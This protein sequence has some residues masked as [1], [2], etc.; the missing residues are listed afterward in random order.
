MTALATEFPATRPLVVARGG[1][2]RW[3]RHPFLYVGRTLDKRRAF[4]A[5]LTQRGYRVAPVTIENADY[6]YA[7]VYSDAKTRGDRAL[8]RQ[9]ADDYL[10]FTERKFVFF[11]DISRRLFGRNIDHVLLLHDNE[12]NAA[13]IDRL[14]ALIQ[15]RGYDFAP[16]ETVLRDP[17]Y[18][19]PDT[20]AG[21]AGVTWL[22]MMRQRSAMRSFVRSRIAVSPAASAARREGTSRTQYIE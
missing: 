17:A 3:F 8:M 20:Y 19:S 7:A 2:L 15:R 5:W 10:A 16:L 12:L 14:A 13:I 11:E 18:A 9:T 1:A 4:E 22:S 6:I 21:G